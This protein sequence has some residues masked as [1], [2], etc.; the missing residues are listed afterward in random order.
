MSA[1]RRLLPRRS[2]DWRSR[3]RSGLSLAVFTKN[4]TAGRSSRS[5]RC[6]RW[7]W[8][9]R[10]T[11]CYPAA[12]SR[13][14]SSFPVLGGMTPER[15][16]R[17]RVKGR[18]SID[19][20]RVR[21]DRGIEVRAV[22]EHDVRIQARDNRVIRRRQDDGYCGFVIGRVH[23]ER[24]C[25]GPGA[26]DQPVVG[27]GAPVVPGVLGK[28]RDTC[29]EVVPWLAKTPMV[30]ATIWVKSGSRAIWKL[31]VRSALSGSDAFVTVRIGVRTETEVAS[32]GL[33]APALWADRSPY[34]PGT[35]QYPS[36]GRRASRHRPGLSSSRSRSR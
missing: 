9:G 15:M 6:R 13:A 30:D 22:L 25:C 31:Y 14:R 28:C 34:S 19:L 32:A 20:E 1:S 11:G 23:E 29:Q 36:R 16:V 17:A 27:L 8:R 18:N 3:V 4:S 24:R 7:P 35:R 5:R 2:K 21:D 33:K 10:S 26:V 12:R